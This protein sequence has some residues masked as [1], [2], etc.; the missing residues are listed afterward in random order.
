MSYQLEMYRLRSPP[1]AI[2]HSWSKRHESA[3]LQLNSPP[4]SSV[5]N[6]SFNLKKVNS[7]S[8]LLTDEILDTFALDDRH[9]DVFCRLKL[10]VNKCDL[11]EAAKND[12]VLQDVFYLSSD[13]IYW[14]ECNVT[15]NGTQLTAV[16]PHTRVTNVK[17]DISYLQTCSINVVSEL[18]STTC[19]CKHV[20]Q[21]KS[22]DGITNLLLATDNK[23]ATVHWLRTLRNKIEA[24]TNSDV[25]LESEMSAPLKVVMML[26]Y[27]FMVKHLSDLDQ[28]VDAALSRLGTSDRLALIG[29]G[30]A[31]LKTVALHDRRWSGWKT[32]VSAML[33]CGP[34][35]SSEEKTDFSDALRA[36]QRILQLSHAHENHDVSIPAI[37]IVDESIALTQQSVRAISRLAKHQVAFTLISVE[38]QHTSEAGEQIEKCGGTQLAV[39]HFEEL[40]LTIARIVS[41][42]RTFTHENVE[43]AIRLPTGIRIGSLQ[44]SSFHRQNNGVLKCSIGKIRSNFSLDI[45]IHLIV[46]VERLCARVLPGE[47]VHLFDTQLKS[48][49]L[50]PCK[51]NE[52]EDS[53]GIECKELAVKIDFDAL[54]LGMLLTGLQPGTPRT[55]QE[56][57]AAELMRWRKPA[58]FLTPR[59]PYLASPSA[60]E[61]DDSLTFSPPTQLEAGVNSMCNFINDLPL[62]DYSYDSSKRLQKMWNYSPA[63]DSSS[64]LSRRLS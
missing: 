22:A 31:Q 9:T 53:K 61:I 7:Y 41:Y 13:G 21:I 38:P 33:A 52:S 16:K 19:E 5:G 4:A 30:G 47:Q 26:P 10:R 14:E 39:S 58:N 11:F 36:A 44:G 57:A 32:A 27:Q 48:E 45:D 55:P 20:L 8:I 50:S 49:L 17:L 34:Q 43:L 62:E 15:F 46:D 54:V 56:C 42:E 60:P 51:N 59:E 63:S 2:P 28:L 12:S 37:I 1:P 40:P 23:T 18:R 6:V 35:T 29:Y 64:L 24:E 25:C 3:P